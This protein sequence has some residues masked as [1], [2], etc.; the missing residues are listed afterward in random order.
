VK[1]E[2]EVGKEEELK[3]ETEMEEMVEGGEE[4]PSP[5][6]QSL[7][8]RGGRGGGDREGTGGGSVDAGGGRD[9][10]SG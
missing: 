3:E 7:L 9:G 6:S 10:G 2:V 5:P 1:E 4:Y 8:E